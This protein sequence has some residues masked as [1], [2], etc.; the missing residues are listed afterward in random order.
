[1][2]AC[3]ARLS[4]TLTFR[5]EIYRF[6]PVYNKKG[7][8]KDLTD[9]DTV[10]FRYS[11]IYLNRFLTEIPPLYELLFHALTAD[12]MKSCSNYAHYRGEKSPQQ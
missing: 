8:P 11:H 10:I 3:A 1:M 12:K 4:V 2:K 6:F 5:I 7:V 9:F